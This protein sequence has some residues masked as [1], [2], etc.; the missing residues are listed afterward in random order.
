M[1]QQSSNW[2]ALALG[3]ARDA[4]A[5]VHSFIIEALRSICND[6]RV[7]DRLLSLLMDGLLEI[8]R[9]SLAQIDFLLKVELSGVPMTVNHYFNDTLEKR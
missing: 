3:Y 9:K 1:R 7:L 5:L 6:D 8:Y 4:V 2:H